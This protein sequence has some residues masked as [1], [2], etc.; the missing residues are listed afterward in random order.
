[1]GEDAPT[2]DA[3]TRENLGRRM[4]ELYEPVWDEEFDPRLAGLLR[5]LD[6][7]GG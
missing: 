7:N 2:L 6:R 3:Q 5:A 1:M 4:Q